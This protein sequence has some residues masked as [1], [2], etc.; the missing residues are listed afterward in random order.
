MRQSDVAWNPPGHLGLL[1]KPTRWAA[2]HQWGPTRRTE[3]NGWLATRPTLPCTND[4]S[5]RI[6]PNQAL[7]MNAT[8]GLQTVGRFQEER[9]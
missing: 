2:L 9:P 5:H 3:L 1:R 4:A 6:E 8:D 7:G